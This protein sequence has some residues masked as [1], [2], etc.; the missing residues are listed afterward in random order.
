MNK[1]LLAFAI[2]VAVLL[3]TESYAS[4]KYRASLGDFT[5]GVTPMQVFNNNSYD[6][7]RK[8]N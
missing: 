2:L 8:G 6:S 7:L 5:P 3:N 4:A 1:L